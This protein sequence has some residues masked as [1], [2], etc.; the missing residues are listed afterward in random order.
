VLLLSSALHPAHPVGG[1][2][3]HAKLPTALP[4]PAC[5]PA[6]INIECAALQPP[7]DYISPLSALSGLKH[8]ALHLHEQL[9]LNS[10]QALVAGLTALTALHVE[11]WT[12]MPY[13]GSL[14]GA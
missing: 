12:Q 1:T 6:C 14:P 11:A 9:P 2:H 8:L 10:W 3:A 13:I 4:T 5:T 7:L